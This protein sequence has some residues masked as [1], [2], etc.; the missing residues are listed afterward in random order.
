MVLKPTS[1][2]F[3]S[4]GVQFGDKKIHAVKNTPIR[5]HLRG[6]VEE[7]ITLKGEH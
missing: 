5:F 3:N 4:K 7:W 6:S 2:E 1:R